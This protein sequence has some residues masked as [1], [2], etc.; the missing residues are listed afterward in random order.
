MIDTSKM[1]KTNIKCNTEPAL[2]QLLLITKLCWSK[3]IEKDNHGMSVVVRFE[4]FIL[5]VVLLSNSFFLFFFPPFIH[6]FSS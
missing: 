5:V 4:L 2:E 3:N 6:S 1:S